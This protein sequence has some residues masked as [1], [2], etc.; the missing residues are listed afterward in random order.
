MSLAELRG[1]LVI[2]VCAISAGIHGALVPG[3]FHERTGAGV[4][5]ALA[6]VL[7]AALAVG[8]TRRPSSERLLVAAAIVF[9]GLLAS[10]VLAVT[11]GVPVLHP[12]PEPVD[13]LA[14]A[15]KA[16]ETIGLLATWSLVRRPRVVLAVTQPKGTLT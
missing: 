9:L 12:E 13:G 16:M 11:T 1:D 10:Y 4:G 5:F 7:L 3:H 8:L 14:L 2:L 15:T 6:T